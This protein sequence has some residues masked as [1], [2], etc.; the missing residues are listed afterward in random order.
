MKEIELS[1]DV[2][3]EIISRYA[4]KESMKNI[5][6]SCK[7]S[8]NT[9]RKTLVNNGV[10][11]RSRGGIEPLDE[12]EVI[13]MYK[14]GVSSSVIAEKF[15]V[16]VHS[17]TNILEKNSVKRDNI[18][19][20]KS[21]VENYWETI[22]SSDKAYFLGFLMTD[23]NVFGNTYVRLQLSSKDE[24]IL[25]TFSRYTKNT[26]NISP[27]K[28]NLSS[29]HVKRKKWVEDLSKY[30]VIPNKTNSLRFLELDNKDMMSHLVRGLFD[31]DGWISEKSH[32]IGFCGNENMVTGLRDYLVKTLNVYKVTV[33]HSE[34]NLWQITWA[35]KKDIKKIGDFIY[36]DKGDCYLTRKYENYE[37]IIQ[38]DTEVSSEIAKGSET[39]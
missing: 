21:L 11:I 29:F 33:I 15:N 14:S 8:V 34:D 26:N 6:I 5:S 9:V 23:G 28:R 27:D 10:V 20:N 1:E 24:E 30:G 36:K 13:L 35:G 4:N 37:K 18:Y 32:Q 22:D 19:H 7:V 39:P 3:K 25:K 12:K 38:A 16:T 17:I 31:G 2:K